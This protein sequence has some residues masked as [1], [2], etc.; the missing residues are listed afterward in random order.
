MTVMKTMH[1]IPIHIDNHQGDITYMLM[2][3][4]GHNA[5]K[6]GLRTVYYILF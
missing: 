4:V 5:H 3:K 2:K 6:Q 1:K